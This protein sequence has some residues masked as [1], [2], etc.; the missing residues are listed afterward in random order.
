MTLILLRKQIWSILQGL[1]R[2]LNFEGVLDEF[3]PTNY[4]HRTTTSHRNRS[5]VTGAQ[6]LYPSCG[7]Y[8]KLPCSTHLSFALSLS[9]A[10]KHVRWP[11]ESSLARTMASMARSFMLCTSLLKSKGQGARLQKTALT[12]SQHRWP[13]RCDS[14]LSRPSDQHSSRQLG[15]G[16]HVISADLLTQCR[17]LPTTA[18]S[19]GLISSGAFA[20]HSSGLWRHASS[21]C[22]PITH[23][24][25]C[26]LLV[27]DSGGL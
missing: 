3:V 11:I 13:F 1:W 23:T 5:T 9:L 27:P 14:Q 10:R 12:T 2:D 25:A 8:L 18:Q 26:L 20:I 6:L 22:L 21:L 17:N 4:T 16:R 19:D 7:P 24:L 15:S